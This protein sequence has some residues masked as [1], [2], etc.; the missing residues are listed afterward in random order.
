MAEPQNPSKEV[1]FTYRDQKINLEDYKHAP[2][3]KAEDVSIISRFEKYMPQDP[4]GDASVDMFD[5]DKLT[6]KLAEVNYRLHGLRNEMR[7]AGRK[8]L[9]SRH[10]YESEKKRRWISITGGDARSREAIAEIMTEA[11]LAEALVAEQVVKELNQ[12]SRDAR[13][14][15]DSLTVQS[16]NIRRQLDVR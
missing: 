3:P 13:I 9:A 1:N 15:L 6:R 12:H 7:I 4:S 11:M 8:A 16:N 14:E 5:I 10:A 2:L